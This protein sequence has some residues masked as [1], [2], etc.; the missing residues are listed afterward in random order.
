[1]TTLDCAAPAS[2]KVPDLKSDA[3][4]EQC[5]GQKLRRFTRNK[6][7][8]ERMETLRYNLIAARVVSSLTAVEAAKRLGYA[9][10]TKLSLIETGQRKTPKDWGFL[11]LASIAWR[12]HR[13]S[14]WRK[15]SHRD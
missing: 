6:N 4:R 10:S 15:P 2:S 7:A 1:M 8:P 14:A 9:N 12:V 5:V 3:K 13:V 11:R